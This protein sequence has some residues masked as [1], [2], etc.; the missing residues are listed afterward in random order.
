MNTLRLYI[1][2][3]VLIG[4]LIAALVLVTLFDL[5]TFSD[6]LKHL[7]KGHYGMRQI[8]LFLA[9]TTPTLLY[10]VIPSAALLGSLSVVGGM[11]NNR[12]IVAMRAAGL[13]TGWIIRSMMLAG[14]VLVLMSTAI[15]ELVAPNCERAAQLLK[16]EALNDNVAMHTRW[17][18]WLREGNNFINVR[19]IEDDSSL[20]DV[21]I[22]EVNPQHQV[23]AF[24]HAE[25]AEFIGNQ[26]WRLHNLQSTQLDEKQITSRAVAE[27][28]LHSNIQTDLLKVAVV[29]ADNQSLTDLFQYIQ[30]LRQNNQKSQRYEVAFWSRLINPLV[31]FVMLMV[32]APLVIGIGRGSSSGARILT[33]V[34]IGEMFDAFDKMTGHVGLIYELNPIAVAVFPSL[35]VFLA[36]LYTLRRTL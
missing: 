17:G 7:N 6:E 3:E 14:L 28:V 2:R 31:T 11:A 35:L 24:N 29:S 16:S 33:G 32:S 10:E 12:E 18:M 15:G 21:R 25:H 36:A 34:V 22:Y 20:T 8:L 4:S 1:V 30:F 19:K 27:K 9:L 23:T 13:S 26:Q 5:F